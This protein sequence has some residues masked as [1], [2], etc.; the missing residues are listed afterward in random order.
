MSK[1][2]VIDDERAIR[3]AMREIL[4]FEE[5]EVDE[6]E[7]GKEAHRKHTFI[8]HIRAQGYKEGR[9]PKTREACWRGIAL[10]KGV[11]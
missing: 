5:F 4:E 9:H 11:K 7:N 2:L 8:R 10:M 1:I 3:R 6:A